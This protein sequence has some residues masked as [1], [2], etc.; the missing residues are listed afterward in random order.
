MIYL[1]G[2]SEADPATLQ[3]VLQGMQGLE[4]PVE[5]TRISDWVLLHSTHATKNVLPKRRLLLTHTKLL[6]AALTCGTVLPARFGLVASTMADVAALI[7]LRQHTISA[8]FDKVRGAFEIG[9]RVNF[10]KAVAIQTTLQSDSGLMASHKA[11]QN[12]GPEA[13]FAIAEFGG[14]LADQLDRRRG[15]AQKQLLAVL[16]DKCRSHVLRKPE[17]D[18]EV[19]RAE[20]LVDV[21]Q[22]ETFQQAVIAAAATLEF[23]PGSDP[24]IEI[25]GP[26]PMYHFVNLNLAF[27][28][29]QEV[30]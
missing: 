24:K 7:K 21:N 26:V 2:L 22:Q 8:E 17:D 12:A 28:D 13:H 5:Q 1:Y 23:A 14:K 20:F 4:G 18:T 3:D 25:V 19:L 11:L 15:A 9:V 30:A 16:M 27:D 6:E 10:D 29:E